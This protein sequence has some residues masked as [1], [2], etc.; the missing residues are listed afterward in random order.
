MNGPST[1]FQT[2]TLPLDWSGH[3]LLAATGGHRVCGDA[4]RRFSGIGIDSRTLA[5]SEAFVAIRGDSH[6]GHRFASEVVA[7]GGRGLV[8]AQDEVPSECLADWQAAG[9]L[10]VAVT[11]TL[12]ALGDL[13]LFH[14]KRNPAR[15]VAITG[16][17]GKTTTRA[18]TTAVL[19]QHHAVISTRGNFNNA[20]GLPLSLFALAPIHQWAVFEIG[21][22]HPG[23]IDRLAQICHPDLGVITNIGP[24]HLEGLGSLDGV[25]EAKGELIARLAPEGR[26]AL[27]A[28]D[29]QVM[30]LAERCTK[31]PL[32]FGL[33]STAEVRA[34]AVRIEGEELRFRLRLPDDAAEVRIPVAAAFMTTNALAAA[35]VGWAAGLAAADIAAGLAAFT[36]VS[37]RMTRLPSGRGVVLIDD[38]YNANPASVKAAIG[39][40]VSQRQGGRT[41]LVLGEMRELGIGAPALHRQAGK[42]AAAAG[43]DRLCVTGPF[44]EETAAGAR[45]GGMAAACIQAAAKEEIVADL[46]AWLAPGDSVLVKGSRAATMETVVAALRHRLLEV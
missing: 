25:R 38:S 6:D 32:R 21:T 35:A 40:L 20:V 45:E 34:E 46:A 26:M 11:D 19:A 22:N 3:Q 31:A 36:P 12:R 33:S 1:G 41:V 28:D 10:C 18:M 7:A 14:R 44:A 29:P 30:R 4:Q 37:G 2:D 23:E 17:N 39:A 15:V 42:D 24:A 16:S 8:L 13:G 9:V 5:V 27:N 43:I